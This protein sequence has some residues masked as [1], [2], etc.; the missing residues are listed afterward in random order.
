[1]KSFAVAIFCL[2][3]V[4]PLLAQAVD[5]TVCD[6]LANPAS[7]DGKIV[8]IKGTV[9]AGFD[10]FAIRG[11]GCNQ[12]VNAI[13]LAYPEGTKAKA[14]AA[15]VVQLQLAKN[16]PS[17][18]TSPARA[19]VTL[20]KNKDF[21]QFDGKLAT[22]GW[23]G[24]ICLGCSRFVVSATLVGRLDG[25]T[26]TGIVRDKI[27]KIVGLEGFG[28][29]NR[30]AARLVLQSVSD[31]APQEIP[32]PKIS[33]SPTGPG[34]E[35]PGGDPVAAAHRA[36]KAFGPNSPAGDRIDRAAS[37]F[38]APGTSNGVVLAF[39]ST[40]E[41][42]KGEGSKGQHDSPDGLL[43]LCTFDMD[44][45]KGNALA[46]AIVH[47]GTHVADARDSQVAPDINLYTLEHGA[48]QAAVLAAVALG[49]KTM[50][51]PGGYLGWDNEW[52][53]ADRG[54]KADEAISKFLSE[55]A[56]LNDSK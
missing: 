14:G 38:G 22:P 29:L 32:Y 12:P 17:A 11:S 15:A 7:F 3:L 34:S 16:N 56:S 53:A 54:K 26:S 44:R 9:V 18:A 46:A 13:W 30:Y 8:R 25:S 42:P 10:E 36:A 50:T 24:G 33:S 27:G 35:D 4:S 49:Q 51:L 55:G 21:K 52:S 19:A 2:V 47:I 43:Y 6:V 48:W 39:G 28:N 37:A 31:V 45:L 5:T 41:I 40:N 23:P 1:M 20:D